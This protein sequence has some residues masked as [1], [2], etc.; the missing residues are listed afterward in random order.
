MRVRSAATLAG[1]VIAAGLFFVLLLMG[2]AWLARPDM[3]FSPPPHSPEEI[4]A[5]EEARAVH[6]DPDNPLRVQ[7]EVDY[8]EGSGAKWYPKGES[9]ILAELVREG[10]LPPLADRVGPEPVVVEGVEGIGKYGGTWIR[11]ANSVPDV[12]IIQNRISYCNLVRWSPQG[13][14]IVPHLAKS[15][16]VSEDSREFV[17]TLRKGMK[18]SDGHPVTVDDI[19]YWWVHEANDQSVTP[20]TALPQ[21]MKQRDKVGTI[22]KIDDY[23]V[24][25]SFPE[26]NGLFLSLLASY[27]GMVMLRCP[28]HYLSKYHP[29]IGDQ[30]LIEQTMQSLNLPSALAVYN[31]MKQWDNPEHPR[32]WPWIYRT[33]RANPPYAFVRNP[34]YFM[35]D[36]EGNQL[37]YLDRVLFDV[38]S[39]DM[40][41][42]TAANGECSMQ[43]R[44]IRYEEYTHLMSQR[45]KNNYEIYNWYPAY[46]SNYVISVNLNRRVDPDRP[47]TSKKLELFNEKK[48]RQAL[49]LA[50]DRKRIIHAEYNDQAEPA[51]I[52][53]G[54]ASYFYEPTLYRS[55]TEHDPETANRLLDEIGLTRHDYEGYRTFKDGS[56]MTLYLNVSFTGMGPS[57]FLVEDWAAVGIR[58]IPRERSRALFS[59]ERSAREHDLNVWTGNGEFLPLL[60]PGWFVPI[61]TDANYA[62]GFGKWYMLGGLQGDPRAQGPGC[63]EPPLDHPLREALEV[64]EDACL[65]SS[66]EDQR[67]IFSR[68]LKI[69][70]ENVWTISICTPPPELVVVKN[71]F[72]NVP[73]F[74]VSSWLFLTPGNAGLETYF[75]DESLD[76]EGTVEQIKQSITKITPRPRSVPVAGTESSGN[77]PVGGGRLG[78]L[79]KYA[80][81]L[82]LAS[83]VVLVAVK[84]PYI[85]RRLLIMIPTLLIISVIVFTIIQL[86]PGDY[87]TTRIMQLRESGDQADI[88]ALEDLRK[89]FYLEDP[90]YLQYMRWLGL[91]WFFTFDADDKG[92]LQGQ[93]GRSMESGQPV[94]DIVGDRIILT[95]LISLGTILFTWALAIPIGIYSAVRQYSVGDYVL[96][97]LGFIGMCV[98]PF[99]L[100]LVL[101]YVSSEFLGINVSG[102]FSSQYAAQAE[103]TWGKVVDLMEHIWVPV[104]VMGVASTAGMIRV[105]RGNLLDE[106]KKPYV[107][108]AMAK[109]V[110][111]VKLLFKYPVRLAINPFVSGIGGL[112]P[113]LVSGGAIVAMVLSLPTVGPLMLSALMSEDMYMAG[114]MLMVLSLL[115]VVGTLVSDL[116]LLW[117]DPRIRFKGGTR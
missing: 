110:R 89:I 64:Y 46:R 16:K 36:T 56:R 76:T 12:A 109:G 84:H 82:I 48:F 33:Y 78:S 73:R 51:Q 1:G 18:W 10:E 9:P 83:L 66:P 60:S 17:F 72:R 11:I 85:A 35:V 43:A 23:T 27:P 21:V 91:K 107:I 5:V 81:L 65:V 74:A 28:A 55:F 57:Q 61:A 42:L 59:V 25:F 68:V 31:L 92:L 41:I 97:F 111:P 114:S 117:L 30:E 32:L 113:Q 69:A 49:S 101:M 115:G 2:M 62:I 26:P 86:P 54:P 80:V 4:E 15:F 39:P 71:G 7:R 63:I 98:P 3:S 90:L 53:P 103:W 24:K 95:V 100:A 52:A 14:P 105:M 67:R 77:T 44:H 108:T 102:L 116:L 38:K 29:T 50:I 20:A 87:L 75:F 58:V 45:S 70:A 106:L 8:S 94:N 88:Q 79:V 37:P 19:M 13:Y 93:L 6:I 99:L 22:E 40:L 104:V 34:Y 47:E 96:T 112:F